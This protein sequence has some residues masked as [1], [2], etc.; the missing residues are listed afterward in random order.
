MSS[1][2]FG[3]ITAKDGRIQQ[4]NF[5]DYLVARIGDAPR[6]VHVHLVESTA[7]PAGVAS[8]ACRPSRRHSATPSSRRRASAC[9]ACRFSKHD[10]SWT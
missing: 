4:G 5:D 7:P 10:L 9:A 1:A 6:E 2:R 3:E 8:R